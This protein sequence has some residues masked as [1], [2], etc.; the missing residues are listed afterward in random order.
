M[1]NTLED[2]VIGNVLPNDDQLLNLI[3]EAN[4]EPLSFLTVVNFAKP[5]YEYVGSNCQP[6]TGYSDETFLR[7][8]PEF[9]FSIATEESRLAS[10]QR[11]VAHFQE[12]KEPGFNPRAVRIDEN[13]FDFTTGF[14]YRKK[15]MVL[16]LPLTYTVNYDMI[17]GIALQAELN[18]ALINTC[19]Q[20]LTAIKERHNLVYQHPSVPKN[21]EPLQKVFIQKRPDQSLTTREE[22][23]LKLMAKGLTSSQIAATLQIAENTVE[24]HRKNIFQKFE[25]KNIAELI[26]KASK[27][28]WL[29]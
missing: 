22:E 17:H 24:T 9:V 25:V 4:V 16:G 28:Y 1:K 26:K 27:L 5:C 7:G 6:I 8:G 29:E 12:A 15:V 20:R 23:V 13:L 3:K 18:E 14:G 21:D 19:K 2:L 10:I 11:Q